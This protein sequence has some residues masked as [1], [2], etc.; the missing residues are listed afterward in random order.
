MFGQ[1][2]IR[3]N[4]AVSDAIFLSE[5]STKTTKLTVTAIALVLVATPITLKMYDLQTSQPSTRPN[6]ISLPVKVACVGDSITQDSEYPYDLQAMLGSNY[7]VRNFGSKE[8]T[9]L[10]LSWKPYMNQTE[11]QSAMDF[12]PDIVVIMLGT[13]DG[14]A[15]LQ[16]FNESFEKEYTALVDSFQQLDGYQQIFIVKSPP[17]FS[18]NTDLNP[19]F[20]SETI[21]PKTEELA[22]K[23]NLPIIDVYNR[24]SDHPDYFE[25]GVHPNS[26]GAALIA[27]E[28]YGAIS[29]QDILTVDTF[30]EVNL[31]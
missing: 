19:A 15:M 12:Q 1:R 13:N 3:I 26:Q 17:I 20:H 22:N 24:C 23:L 31:I 6:A 8:S 10:R 29:E 21:I 16:P 25:D 30:G 14:L 18:N 5:V 11:F 9:V 27:F 2:P 4:Q 28:V 7:S